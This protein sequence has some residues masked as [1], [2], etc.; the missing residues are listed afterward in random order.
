[1]TGNAEPRAVIGIDLGTTNCALAYTQ[2]EMVEQFAIPQFV[3]PGEMRDEPLLPLP[4]FL[5]L[6]N[7]DA[8]VGVLAQKRK[9]WKTQAGWS[10]PPSRGYRIPASIAQPPFCRRTHSDGV[11]ADLPGG[12]FST[13]T[14]STAAPAWVHEEPRG[15]L[16]PH[17]RCWS[18]CRHLS[19]RWP[20]I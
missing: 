12:S 16:S 7:G 15:F 18:R 8:I 4:S 11:P 17:A 19:M 10:P 9:A 5:F 3:H 20:A 14:F 2:N 1:M 13:V 6:E